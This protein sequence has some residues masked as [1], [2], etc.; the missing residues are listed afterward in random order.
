MRD[1]LSKT[2]VVLKDIVQE[3][4]EAHMQSSGLTYNDLCLRI[5]ESKFRSCLLKTLS[6][7]FRLVSSYYV[8]MSFQFENK[9]LA[10]QT[11]NVS[12]KRSDTTLSR[13]EQQI[14]SIHTTSGGRKVVNHDCMQGLQVYYSLGG[15]TLVL[16]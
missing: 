5:P 2:R 14:E 12:Q 7:F 8:I 4:Q 3:D 1:V 9:A 11:S 6:G 13:D 15:V 10:C 16:A